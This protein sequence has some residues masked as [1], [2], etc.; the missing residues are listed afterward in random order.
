[1]S[2][3]LICW[4]KM[5]KPLT[6]NVIYTCIVFILYTIYL[7]CYFFKLITVKHYDVWHE[8]DHFSTV[9]PKCWSCVHVDLR[10]SELPAQL[11]THSSDPQCTCYPR[12][13]SV[14]LACASTLLVGLFGDV[15]HPLAP[16]SVKSPRGPDHS[17]ANIWFELTSQ[18]QALHTWGWL[19]SHR[20]RWSA[21]VVSNCLCT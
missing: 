16:P 4:V 1:M 7:Q 14:L 13:K 9:Y 8:Y 17:K 18:K 11:S 2:C 3:R 5:E 6:L 21:Y 12:S 10:Q 20:A 15:V 19:R